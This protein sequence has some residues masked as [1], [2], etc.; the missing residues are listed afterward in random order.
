MA[1]TQKKDNVTVPIKPSLGFEATVK[2]RLYNQRTLVLSGEI[3]EYEAC[4]LTQLL[5]A[6]AESS[7]PITLLITSYG[8]AVEAGGTIIRAIR[9]AQSN[10]CE[11]IG[12]VRGY[13]MSMGAAILQACDLRFAAP[14][15]IV[16]VHGFT[17]QSVGDIRNTEADAKM[18]RQLTTIY[19]KFYA[20]RST[21]EDTKYHGEEYWSTL[22]KDSLPHYYFGYEA[23]EKGLIDEVIL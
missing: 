5:Q 20:E 4:A 2:A 23:L 12:E 10:G 15:D 21:A 9:Y 17:G 18:T 3:E 7:E 16:M 13:A 11:V 8:G 6:L 19:A 1:S 14:E 22:L